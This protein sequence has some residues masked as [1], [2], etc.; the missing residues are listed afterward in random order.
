MEVT[1]E[2]VEQ[3]RPEWKEG[4]DTG[5][6]KMEGKSNVRFPFKDFWL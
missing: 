6:E 3:E 2:L 1:V 4:M 5:P